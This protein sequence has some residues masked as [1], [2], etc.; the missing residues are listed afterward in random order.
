MGGMFIALDSVV[1]PLNAPVTV[2]FQP[3]ADDSLVCLHVPGMV[4]H[5][6]ADGVGLMFDELE[7]SCKTAI[8]RLLGAPAPDQTNKQSNRLVR[9]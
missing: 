3:S 1:M 2:S 6:H 5:Q 4:V 8:R 7:P 9:A